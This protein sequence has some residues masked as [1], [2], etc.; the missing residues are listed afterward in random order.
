MKFHLK[1]LA[2]VGLAILAGWSPGLAA[3]VSVSLDRTEIVL[4][5]TVTLILQTAD[6][7]QS[8]E[9]DY[10][11]GNQSATV[12]VLT[13]L[14]PKRVGVLVIPAMQFPGASTSEIRLTVKP[15]APLAPGQLEPVFIELELAPREGPY[16]VMAQISLT[17]RVFYQQNLTE[18]AMNPP[19]PEQASV[20]LLDEVPYQTQRNGNRYRVLERHFAVFPERS[21]TLVIPPLELSG[22]LVERPADR[23]WQPSVRGRRVRIESEP[24]MIAI[25]PRPDSFDGDHW[26]PARKIQLSQNISDNPGLRA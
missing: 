10:V 6:P 1:L 9:A 13:T 7:K 26:L 12:R 21:G 18:A 14:E 16:Y 19:E 22:R 15:P 11:N 4:G 25:L 8:L 5:E 20:R 23:L 2:S 24:L 17:V 3:Q